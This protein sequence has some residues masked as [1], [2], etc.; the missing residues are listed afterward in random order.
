MQHTA[1][2]RVDRPTLIH[3]DIA[4]WESMARFTRVSSSLVL[5]STISIGGA[6]FDRICPVTYAFLA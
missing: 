3:L 6:R 4:T 2:N 5:S 1:E